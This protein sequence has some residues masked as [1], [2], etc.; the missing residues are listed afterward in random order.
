MTPLSQFLL[1]L[2]AFEALLA[3]C[4]RRDGVRLRQLLDLTA[5]ERVLQGA[6]RLKTGALAEAAALQE[7]LRRRRAC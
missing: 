3:H 2:R 4:S 7:S 6:G 5:K 1:D